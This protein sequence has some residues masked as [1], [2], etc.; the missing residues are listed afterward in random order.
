MCKTLKKWTLFCVVLAVIFGSFHLSVLADEQIKVMVNGKALSLEKPPILDNGRTLIPMRAIFEVLG[1]NVTYYGEVS[2]IYCE[3]ETATAKTT[4]GISLIPK[5]M[6]VMSYN[7]ADTS[8]TET[9]KQTMFNKGFDESNPIK[10]ING[11]T[12]LPAR[13]IAEALGCKV[14]WDGANKTV[15]IDTSNTKITVPEGWTDSFLAHCKTYAIDYIPYA[16]QMISQDKRGILNF[17][18]TGGQIANIPQP[19]IDNLAA[20]NGFKPT[21]IMIDGKLYSIE[22]KK[23]TNGSEM[24]TATPKGHNGDKIYGLLRRPL[25]LYNQKTYIIFDCVANN[26]FEYVYTNPINSSQPPLVGSVLAKIV[27]D[28][29]KSTE[30][31]LEIPRKPYEAETN[32]TEAYATGD[33][34]GCEWY[35]G[36]RFDE[37]FG[38]P[39][40]YFNET[41]SKMLY[42]ADTFL[43]VADKYEQLTVIRDINN[44]PDSGIVVLGIGNDGV[45]HVGFI[46]YV[47]RDSSGK[48]INVYYSEGNMKA[49]GKYHHGI[50]G[51]VQKRNFISFLK[52][53]SKPVIGYIIPNKDYYK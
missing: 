43:E 38:I 10:I 45:G 15:K 53:G 1:Y 35:A 27:L 31:F 26:F 24:I 16:E 34:G 40:R 50:D 13:H 28:E 32:V 18:R 46:E 6:T 9:V 48:P 39:I 44:I 17:D 42:D 3:K 21:E 22:R 29:N 2:K 47:E 33:Y 36:G 20:D 52:Q 37:V 41:K 23:E 11:T 19:N 7:Y 51:T 4:C 30:L 12:Y 8:K 25:G 14:D 49:D 5:F